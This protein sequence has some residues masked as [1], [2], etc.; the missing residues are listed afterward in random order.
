[1]NG[2]LLYNF[3]NKVSQTIL[4]FLLIDFVAVKVGSSRM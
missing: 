1:M 3:I 2:H 4:G